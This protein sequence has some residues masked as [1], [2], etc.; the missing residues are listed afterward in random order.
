[1]GLLTILKKMKQK[2]KEVRLLMLYPNG[3]PGLLTGKCYLTRISVRL[4]T[5]AIKIIE[6]VIH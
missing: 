4:C 2:E 5:L 6:L 1:M 3:C